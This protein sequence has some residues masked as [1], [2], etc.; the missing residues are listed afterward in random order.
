MPPESYDQ[1]EGYADLPDYAVSA[2]QDPDAD[3]IPSQAESLAEME[4][5]AAATHASPKHPPG[6]DCAACGFARSEGATYTGTD[7]DDEPPELYTQDAEE[8]PYPVPVYPKPAS[9]G[10]GGEP[11]EIYTQ[12]AEEELPAVFSHPKH[13]PGCDCSACG[14]A[15]QEFASYD[16][17]VVPGESAGSDPYARTDVVVR[18][19]E[20]RG[21]GPSARDRAGPAPAR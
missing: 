13:P 18:G 21:A 10:A 6:C 4:A 9:R 7:V 11:P 20:N 15:R 3:D 14:F 19:A 12:H 17:R 2:A 8:E 1:A 16:D 5:G